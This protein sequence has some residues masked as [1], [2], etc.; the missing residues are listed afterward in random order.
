MKLSGVPLSVKV[1]SEIFI[2]P[3]VLADTL[4]ALRVMASDKDCS[5]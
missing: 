3:I 1:P 2:V 5:F 4:I